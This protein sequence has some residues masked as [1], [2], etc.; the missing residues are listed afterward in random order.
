M[1]TDAY[2]CAGGSACRGMHELYMYVYIDNICIYMYTYIH[3]WWQ[4]SGTCLQPHTCTIFLLLDYIN[5]KFRS[6]QDYMN[7]KWENLWTP[8]C[9]SKKKQPASLY[10]YWF[11]DW[12]CRNM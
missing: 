3:G 2:M 11:T 1:H 4:V 7:T 9:F 8:K 10:L 5:R 6:T 12:V